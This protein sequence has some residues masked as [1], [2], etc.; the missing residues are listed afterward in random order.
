MKI[1]VKYCF[2]QSKNQKNAAFFRIKKKLEEDLLQANFSGDWKRRQEINL[3]LLWLKKIEEDEKTKKF[4]NDVYK[5]YTPSEINKSCYEY[6]FLNRYYV[7]RKV[8][9]NLAESKTKYFT[10]QK[11]KVIP[12]KIA[13][14]QNVKK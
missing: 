11:G 4:Y 1:L 5:F 6:S 10:Q 14:K 9:A 12:G 7:F 3:Q 13:D 8:E 2:F